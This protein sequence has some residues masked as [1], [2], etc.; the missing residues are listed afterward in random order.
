MIRFPI[1]DKP[2]KLKGVIIG[3]GSGPS[4]RIKYL[5]KCVTQLIR[6]ERIEGRED[7]MDE[8]RGY[9]E[10]LINL[11]IQHGDRHKRTMEIADSWLLEKDLV[12]KL[13][14]VLAPRYQQYSTSFTAM[15]RL[16]AR[17]PSSGSFNTV[18]EL[19]GNPY[20]PVI[21]HQRE[22]RHLLTNVLLSAAS[23]DYYKGKNEAAPS[24]RVTS[25]ESSGN[26]QEDDS[27]D[28][29]AEDS[30]TVNVSSESSERP[31]DNS[32]ARGPTT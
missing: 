25:A 23:R 32:G 8:T 1:Q 24:D 29:S 6:H 15:H 11:A 2:R 14:K 10:Q 30:V 26:T 9:A 5:K 27:K 18:L 17:Y 3:C 20:P 28:N 22:T 4:E 16:P 13:F 12:H 31:A 19:K 21:P 7:R